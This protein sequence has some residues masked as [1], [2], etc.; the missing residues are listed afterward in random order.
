MIPLRVLLRLCSAFIGPT[1]GGIVRLC[2][3]LPQCCSTR[4]AGL[5]QGDIFLS[6]LGSPLPVVTGLFS[7]SPD[8][9]RDT[10]TANR[11]TQKSH[12]ALSMR[13][14]WCLVSSGLPARRH[15]R[16]HPS[17]STTGR[18][19][20]HSATAEHIRPNECEEP[21]YWCGMALLADHLHRSTAESPTPSIECHGKREVIAG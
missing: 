11:M 13:L 14:C 3:N 15:Y 10:A 4:D 16:P 18:P 21:N 20:C 6:G 12:T 17:L 1:S 19:W 2:F 7:N 5:K 9:H 8:R